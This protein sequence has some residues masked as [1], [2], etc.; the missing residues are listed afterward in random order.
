MLFFQAILI[1]FEQGW[2][3]VF[4]NKILRQRPPPMVF[5][6][7][8][9]SSVMIPHQQS[10][11]PPERALSEGEGWGREG[12]AGAQ[13]WR[14]AASTCNCRNTPSVLEWPKKVGGKDNLKK[15]YLKK[16]ANM[17]GRETEQALRES[18]QLP[19]SMFKNIYITAL[20]YF[21]YVTVE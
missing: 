7:V 20:Q 11:C 6:L 4:A 9:S 15:Q 14:N 21:F 13:D 2:F 10:T 18:E 17:F 5:L 8:K 16:A 12:N 1:G 3:N 19:P